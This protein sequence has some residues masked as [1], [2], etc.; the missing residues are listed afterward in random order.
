MGVTRAI[1]WKRLCIYT[2]GNVTSACEFKSFGLGYEVTFFPMIVVT[3]SPKRDGHVIRYR[4]VPSWML[5]DS[6]MKAVETLHN[7]YLDYLHNKNA[8]L[9]I[10]PNDY[11]DALT[12][13]QDIPCDYDLFLDDLNCF[14]LLGVI[15]LPI[16]PIYNLGLVAS[17]YNT[18]PNIRSFLLQLGCV[19]NTQI[20][21]KLAYCLVKPRE[22]CMKIISNLL[23]SRIIQTGR[24]GLYMSDTVAVMLH[25]LKTQTDVHHVLLK[26]VPF[27]IS[28]AKDIQLL[29]HLDRLITNALPFKPILPSPSRTALHRLKCIYKDYIKTYEQYLSLFFL[30]MWAY[31]YGCENDAR[32]VSGVC[33]KGHSALVPSTPYCR[34]ELF[35]EDKVTCKACGSDDFGHETSLGGFCVTCEYI[36]ET[37]ELY[38]RWCDD[39]TRTSV[40]PSFPVKNDLGDKR[41]CLSCYKIKPQRDALRVRRSERLKDIRSRIGKE[42][43][44]LG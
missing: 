36:S 8:F 20:P 27:F 15:E 29:P 33:E 26:L 5:T 43:E 21:F 41:I 13:L 2:T 17:F 6:F 31:C 14:Q 9:H 44:S 18:D 1:D 28:N 7:C 34:R 16:P 42:Q 23:E 22:T 4:F 24:H 10:R 12:F 40:P 11:Y 32:V 25:N 35:L 37:T 19:H 30:F 3:V 39:N 38:C